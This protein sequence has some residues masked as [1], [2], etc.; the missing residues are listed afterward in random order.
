M[1]PQIAVSRMA[2]DGG[3]PAGVFISIPTYGTLRDPK[4]SRNQNVSVQKTF[5]SKIA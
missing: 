4:S 1:L 2:N 3:L 5:R